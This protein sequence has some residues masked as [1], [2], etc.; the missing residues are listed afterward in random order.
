MV[1]IAQTAVQYLVEFLVIA[2]IIQALLSWVI[3]MGSGNPLM[4]L[5]N[6]ITAPILNPIRRTIP[7]LGG[8]DLSPLI[9]ILVLQLLVG[10]VLLR[11]T[12]L[13]AGG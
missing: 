4:V 8:L 2:I 7:P 5:L 1:S 12:T 6:D 3:P 9:A 13:L 11:L 10:P